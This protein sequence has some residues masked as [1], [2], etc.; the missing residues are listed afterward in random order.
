MSLSENENHKVKNKIKYWTYKIE[1]ILHE[2][3]NKCASYKWMHE[4]E[5]DILSSRNKMLNIL[6]IAIV[7]LSATGSIITNDLFSN[8][9]QFLQ[10]FNII[11]AIML[12]M[13][14][15]MSSLQHFLNYEKEAEKHRTVSVKYTTL[16]NNIKRMLSLDSEQR[17]SVDNYFTWVNKEYDSIFLSAP[18]ISS[19]TVLNFE[20][21]F[22]TDLSLIITDTNNDTNSEIVVIDDNPEE[23][24]I[25][26]NNYNTE[27]LKYEL[28]RFMIHSYNC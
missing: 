5:C 2:Q 4:Y 13:T 25:S 6:N 1:K 24:N 7:S 18:D 14:S 12:Y 8:E 21:K 28:D 16:Y 23:N 11:Y 17:Q 26:S 27:K 20:T 15:V 10:I 22:N 3:K 19:S 9:K